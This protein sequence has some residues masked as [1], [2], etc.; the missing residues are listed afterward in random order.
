VLFLGGANVRNADLSL[1]DLRGANLYAGD[2]HGVTFY[3]TIPDDA[4]LAKAIRLEG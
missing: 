2:L 1:A 4:D 3:E